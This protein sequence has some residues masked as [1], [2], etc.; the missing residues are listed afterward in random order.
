MTKESL[1]E[2]GLTEDQAKK[3]TEALNGSFV[4]K[5][6]FNE[7]NAEL[8]TAKATIKERNSQLEDLQKSTGDV[9]AMKAQIT[10]LQTANAK[11]Q[12][13]YDAKLKR[14]RIDNAVD[15]ALKD[16]KAINLATVRPLLAAFLEKADVSDD[17]TIRGLSD[18]V[19]KLVKDESTRFLFKVDPPAPTVSGV[20][21][22]GS[23]TIAPDEKSTAYET[24]LAEARKAGNSAL[25]VS[26]KREAAADGVQLF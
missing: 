25:V 10:E 24:R 14:L 21:P 1:M 18:E 6:R 26:I 11:Q 3:V 17:G 15:S 19:E 5:T 9:E 20:S 7:I 22:A 16:A 13:E 4:P 12:K 23:V 2:I 8:Q